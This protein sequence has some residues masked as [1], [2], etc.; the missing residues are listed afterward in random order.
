MIFTKHTATFLM[1]I[2]FLYANSASAAPAKPAAK[3]A[4]PAAKSAAPKAGAG[5]AAGAP[6]A[7][8]NSYADQMRNKMGGKWDYPSG[9]NSVTLVVKV[10]QDGSVS[11]LSLSSSPKNTEAEQKA[12]DAFNSA[13][14]LQPLPGG[15]ASAVITCKFDSQA[16]QWNSKANI[17]VRI[18]PQ[19]AAE[20]AATTDG[21][22]TPSTPTP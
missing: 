9:N 8:L 6:S 15:T 20:P 4:T 7:A 21:G 10:S 22:S 12:N 13:Q 14:P 5:S 19:K 3:K 16:D 18:D 2:S 17:A 11:D 1:A